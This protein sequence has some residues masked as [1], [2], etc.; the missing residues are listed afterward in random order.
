MPIE[1]VATDPR[2]KQDV[3]G[4]RAIL[5]SSLVYCAGQAN[6]KNINLDQ[7]SLNPNNQFKVIATSGLLKNIIGDRQKILYS[8]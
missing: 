5:C 6:N 2:V 3:V 7:I 1:V 8:S 4:K